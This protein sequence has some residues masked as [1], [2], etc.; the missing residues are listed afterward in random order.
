V[1]LRIAGPIYRFEQVLKAVNEGDL[2]VSAILRKNDNF[3]ESG[4]TLNDTMENLRHRVELIQDSAFALRDQVAGDAAAS[5]LA[6]SL[7]RQLSVFKV[8]KDPLP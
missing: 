3:I 4:A 2:T 8:H 7:C 5:Q 6:D 1:S